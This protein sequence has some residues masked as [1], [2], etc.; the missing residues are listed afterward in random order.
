MGG[1]SAGAGAGEK[2]G[3]AQCLSTFSICSL[4]DVA[5]I[6]KR[7]LY[8]QLYVF[9]NRELTKDM[10]ARAKAAGIKTLVITVDTAGA[11][12]R[13]KDD[14]NGFPARRPPRPSMLANIVMPPPSWLVAVARRRPRRC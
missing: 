5:A 4:E 13:P 3:I 8:Y 1:E 14:P 9:R 7:S 10:V 11:P 6:K 2:A 12:P